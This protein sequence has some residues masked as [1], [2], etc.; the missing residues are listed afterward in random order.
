MATAPRRATGANVYINGAFEAAYGT[1]ATGNWNGLRAYSYGLAAGQD[2]LDEPLLGA[3]RDPDAYQLGAID[4]LGNVVVP[5]D[6]RLFGHWLKLFL[7]T[8]QS[9]TQ[10]GSRGYIDFSALPAASSTITLAGTAWTFV[11]SGATGP[12]TNIG[13]SVAATVTQLAS[14]LNA[15]A[16]PAISA[17]TYTADGTR[18]RIQHDTA[19]TAGNSF[20]LAAGATSNG[21]V[22]GATLAGGGLYRHL[23]YSGAASLPSMSL[24]TEHRDLTPGD[25]RFYQR[26]GVGGNTLQI[27][28]TRAGSVRAQLGL[29][30]QSET[31]TTTS[32]AGTP[33]QLPV[34]L[35]SQF[36]GSIRFAGEGSANLTAGNFAFGNNLDAVPVIDNDG[37]IG[38]LDPGQT[39]IGFSLTGRLSSTTLK[40]KADA[41]EAAELQFG[42]RSPANGAELLFTAHQVQLP[43]PR[44]EISGPGG[45]EMTWD[46][47]GSRAVALGRAMQVEL[48]NDV[49]AY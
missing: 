49:A 28:R 14:D 12:Q 6:Q 41:G 30:G 21:K 29:I 19:T 32:Q 45:I 36:Q 4:V 1:Q 15:S 18:L 27:D 11:A 3:G 8:A 34:D 13:A 24:E 25:L 7:G 38:G 2:L 9:D 47:R 39:T 43:K 48:F 22:S 20:T 44:N 5:V 26:L 42:F 35:F 10:V 31:K 40:A 17:A 16:V 37:L 33:V 23:W 46:A